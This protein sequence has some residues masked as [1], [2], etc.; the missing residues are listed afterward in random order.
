VTRPLTC[1]AVVLASVVL[2]AA[3][4]VGTVGCGARQH[5]PLDAPQYE[6]PVGPVDA[7]AP[8]SPTARS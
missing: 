8:A 1:A 2:L 3:G 4:A 7:A 5:I 6:D